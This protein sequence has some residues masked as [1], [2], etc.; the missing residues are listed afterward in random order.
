MVNNT[1]VIYESSQLQKIYI[2]ISQAYVLDDRDAGV[3]IQVVQSFK[4]ILCS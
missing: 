3:F 1:F 2:L 4:Y